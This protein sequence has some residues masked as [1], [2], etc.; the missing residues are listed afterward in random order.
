M[1]AAITVRPMTD[2]DIAATA[3]VRRAAIQWLERSQGRTPDVPTVPPRPVLHR[4]IL[5]TDPGGCWVAE[6][7]DLVLGYSQSFIRGDLWFLS[8]LFVQPE[9]HAH[10]AG[11]A[12][13]ER[14]VAYGDASG[15]RIRSVV[16]SSSPVAHALYARQGMFTA[17]LGY[18]L[19]GPA[20]ALLALPA[21]SGN[22]KRVVDCSGWQDRI[23]GAGPRRTRD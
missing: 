18:R 4:H 12:V 5:R 1:T 8:Q 20:D 19:S 2:A 21:P 10:G 9:V 3:L 22:Q 23:A 11:R 16:A 14:A 15:A 17:G 6:M 7:N 13:L